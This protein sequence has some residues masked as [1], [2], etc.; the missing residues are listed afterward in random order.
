MESI[1]FYNT[2]IQLIDNRSDIAGYLHGVQSI[3]YS[4]SVVMFEFFDVGRVSKSAYEGIVDFEISLER[5]LANYSNGS[6]RIFGPLLHHIFSISD[7]K[8]SRS[9]GPISYSNAFFPNNFGISCSGDTLK[10]IKDF[11]IRLATKDLQYT[12]ISSPTYDTLFKKCMLKNLE[13]TIEVGSVLKERSNF[14]SRIRLESSDPEFIKTVVNLEETTSFNERIN[15]LK[16]ENFNYSNSILP[17][18]I[19]NLC[20]DGLISNGVPVHALQSISISMNLEYSNPMDSGNILG[21]SNNEY[22]NLFKFFKFPM[23]ISCRFKIIAQ[24]EIPE[25]LLKD[26]NF[27]ESKI[28]IV[29]KCSN[30]NPASNTPNYLVFHL[31]KRNRIASVSKSGG[32]VSGEPYEYEFEYKN[33]N[34]D[35]CCYFTDHTNFSLIDESLEKF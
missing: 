16:D 30:F 17:N 19:S 10:D 22:V 3:D 24:R 23:D 20:N 5:V 9:S 6:N 15:I 33:V 2:G 25:I 13:Y 14:S 32:S 4:A 29:F 34:N 11:D 12:D 28:V 18:F 35:I 21:A 7:S 27:G 31:G 8:Y 26:T 1:R